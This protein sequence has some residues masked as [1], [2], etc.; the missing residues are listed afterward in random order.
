MDYNQIVELSGI[1]GLLF[2]MTIF[3]FVMF[4]A[5]RPGAKQKFER[6]GK[7]PFKED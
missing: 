6:Y 2:F 7:I 5:F 4:Y 1:V 3:L